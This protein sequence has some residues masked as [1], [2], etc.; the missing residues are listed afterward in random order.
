MRE[1]ELVNA[2]QAAF[3]K[4]CPACG[5]DLPMSASECSGCG[6]DLPRE[7]ES[8]PLSF[9]HQAGL[10]SLRPDSSEGSTNLRTLR[11]CLEGVQKQT[12]SLVEYLDQVGEVYDEVT[13]NLELLTSPIIVESLK[14]QDDSLVAIHG[15]A[16]AALQAFQA[17]CELM[18][19]Y[20]GDKDFS[21]AEQGLQQVELALAEVDE[22]ELS[23]SEALAEIE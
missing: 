6:G 20:A 12:M 14:E 16:V 8:A 10:E 21:P 3:L 15:R 23:A 22:S 4:R 18:M 9:L 17:G 13:N 19:G 5:Q 1:S 7:E 11:R 2:F